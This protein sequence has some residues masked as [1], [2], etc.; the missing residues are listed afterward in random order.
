M[1]QA[2]INLPSSHP[3]RAMTGLAKAIAI[4]A[5]HAPVRFPSFPALERTAVMSFNQPTTLNLKSEKSTKIML[6]RQ[7]GYPAWAEQPNAGT[8]F[9]YQYAISGVSGY[10][11]SSYTM[12]TTNLIHTSIGDV[13]GGVSGPY[14]RPAVLQDNAAEYTFPYAPVALDSNTGSLPWFWAPDGSTVTVSVSAD[15]PF[16]TSTQFS[17]NMEAWSSPGQVAGFDLTVGPV[18]SASTWMGIGPLNTFAGAGTWYRPKSVE[19]T[20]STAVSEFGFAMSLFVIVSMGAQTGTL[21]GNGSVTVTATPGQRALMPLV[22]SSEFKNSLLPWYATRTLAASLLGTN[23]TQILNKSGTVLGGRVSPN[24]VNPFHVDQ[25][26]ISAL[27]P[28]EKAWL[29]LETGVYTYAPPSTDLANFWDYTLPTGGYA[30][31][32]ATGVGPF[33]SPDPAPVYRLDNDS[34]V[35]IMFVTPGPADES[36]AVTVSWHIEFRTSSALFQVALSGMTLETL[37]QAQLTLAA[38][39]FF[40]DN[41]DHRAIISKVVSAANKIAPIAFGALRAY[42][43]AVAAMA[44]KGYNYVAKGYNAARK[45]AVPAGP[46]KMPTTTASKSGMD[47][48]PSGT[49]GRGRPRKT[50]HSKSATKKGK[51]K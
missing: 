6:S 38:A 36:L 11:A 42:N 34:L 8:H 45:V 48:K 25:S 13:L 33:T 31:G 47:G 15:N 39:G 1:Q 29:P 30:E 27:H 49:G 40:F 21:G 16:Q 50:E 3:V 2:T 26:Y 22:V 35:N 24:V 10:V 43:P 4:P 23:V 12:L 37:H 7:A 44:R 41:P 9:Q 18:L 51:G 20:M 14:R 46:S 17:I 5:E 19:Q 32:T 28:A